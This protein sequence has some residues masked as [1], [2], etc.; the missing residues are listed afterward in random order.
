MVNYLVLEE[1]LEDKKRYRVGFHR[2]KKHGK[3]K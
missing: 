1:N 3:D 2:S